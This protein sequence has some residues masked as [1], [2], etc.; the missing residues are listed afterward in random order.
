M[1]S[2]IHATPDLS[3]PL[4]SGLNGCKSKYNV[5]YH[6]QAKFGEALFPDSFFRLKVF[7]DLVEEKLM[8]L[9]IFEIKGTPDRIVSKE[10]PSEEGGYF[11]DMLSLH[12]D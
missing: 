2:D 6:I 5:D 11:W 9:F 4:W 7:L 12:T 1:F 3:Q 8:N 10:V